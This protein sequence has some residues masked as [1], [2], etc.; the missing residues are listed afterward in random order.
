M[1]AWT[2]CLFKPYVKLAVSLAMIE[3]HCR[4]P[5]R[6]RPCSVRF[7]LDTPLDTPSGLQTLVYSIRYIPSI[8]LSQT[9]QQLLRDTLCKLGLQSI[10]R[11]SA[12]LRQR[13]KPLPST[14]GRNGRNDAENISNVFFTDTGITLWVLSRRNMPWHVMHHSKVLCSSLTVRWD[15]APNSKEK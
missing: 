1:G 3:C 10:D 15:T 2:T 7:P 6:Q 11:C 4:S 12:P 8:K 9:G 5:S 13:P 14:T